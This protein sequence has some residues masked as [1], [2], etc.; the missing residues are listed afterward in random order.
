MIWIDALAQEACDD[1][2]QHVPAAAL[3][4]AGVTAVC[5]GD[6]DRGPE[7]TAAYTAVFRTAIDEGRLPAA[8]AP[9]G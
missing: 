2:G 6:R 7:Y 8:P 3:A 9:E 5:L 1:T 4:E